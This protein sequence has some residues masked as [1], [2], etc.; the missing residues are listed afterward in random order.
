MNYYKN[1]LDRLTETEFFKSLKV[2]NGDGKNTNQMGINL[3]SIPVLID[4]LK[5]EEKRLKQ[6]KK[7]SK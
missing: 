4:F 6:I 1:Q 5:T 7:E 3:E 2:Y